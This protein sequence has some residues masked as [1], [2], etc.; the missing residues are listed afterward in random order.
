MPKLPYKHKM[1]MI[2]D[3]TE[4]FT[5]SVMNLSTSISAVYY[6]VKKT[7]NQDVVTFQKTLS[8]GITNS[9]GTYTVT[10]APSDTVNLEPGSYVY[11]LKIIYGSNKKVLLSGDLELLRG[12]TED[13]RA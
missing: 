8:N 10:I 1:S 2:R 4:T 9:D 12:V 11:D 13:G 6:T 5:F 7:V 3:T